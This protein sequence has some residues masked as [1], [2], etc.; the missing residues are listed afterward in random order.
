L[1]IKN[2]IEFNTKPELAV[3]LCREF[4]A[5]TT[6]PP[7]AA[8]DE[9]YGRSGDLR[10]FLEEHDVG[11]V[12]SRE[13]AYHYCHVPP[14]R[15]V[16][17][18]TL[19]HVACLRWPVEEDFEFGK[20]CFGLDQSQVRICTTLDRHIVLTM[21]VL[22]VC[23][24]TAAQ[25]KTTAPPPVPLAVTNPATTC[26]GANGDADTKPAR[27][28]HHHPSTTRRDHSMTAKCSCRTSASPRKVDVV[29]V[30]G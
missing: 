29:I 1:G 9:V 15:P 13:L 2:D 20:D 14:G 16:I 3:E 30:S 27:W 17:L 7:W 4:A 8:G 22:A 11:Y 18:A 24:V 10:A 26:D 12:T 5:D 23:A 25:A 28:F 6:M 21:A 19:I